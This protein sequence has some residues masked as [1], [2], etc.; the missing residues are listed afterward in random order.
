[1]VR[2]GAPPLA[3]AATAIQA[4]RQVWQSH[5]MVEITMEDLVSILLAAELGQTATLQDLYDDAVERDTHLA[6]V[7]ERRRTNIAGR[8]LYFRTPD[9]LEA[10]D[11]AVANVKLAETALAQFESPSG[12][13]LDMTDGIGRGW[14]VEEL[15][16]GTTTEGYWI[17]R[18]AHWI[19]ANRIA[20]D[21][22]VMEPRRYDAGVD[23][24]PGTK[25][26]DVKG[27][28]DGFVFHSPR[29]QGVYPPRRG[30]LRSCM[31]LVLVKRYGIRWWT[32]GLERFGI[33]GLWAEILEGDDELK[34]DAEDFLRKLSADWIAVA[35]KGF[36]VHQ[37]E[38]SGK[39]DGGAHEKLARFVDEQTSKRVLG[40]TLTTDAPTLGGSRAQGDV[41]SSRELALERWDGIQL[42]EDFRR[43]FLRPLV[44]YNRPGT[45]VPLACFDV[46]DETLEIPVHYFSVPVFR[47]NEIRASLGYPEV[48]DGT[49]DEYMVAGVQASATPAPA[50]G[51]E[52]PAPSPTATSPL[53]QSARPSS[54]PTSSTSTRGLSALLSS[55]TGP[56]TSSPSAST[57]GSPTGAPSTTRR[58]GSTSRAGRRP[59]ARATSTRR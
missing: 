46:P 59:S 11:D 36:Q 48:E 5:P 26:E 22:S 50:G 9:G 4:V 55:A 20:W 12:L 34:A 42:A 45:P 53:A 23:K 56:S 14:S 13:V 1:M 29:L 21:T 27:G 58:S 38:A 16:W 33:P 39:F 3:K 35:T 44:K 30:I 52:P 2:S 47:K 54:S 31:W 49:G 41:H 51:G 8:E 43:D 17:P 37:I 6:T 25:F 40:Q 28:P 10:D 19:H 7:Y 24:F 32:V 57:S 18:R 15:D